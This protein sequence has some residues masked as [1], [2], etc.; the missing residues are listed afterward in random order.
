[1]HPSA[2]AAPSP[3]LSGI[4]RPAAHRRWGTCGG[5]ALAWPGRLKENGPMTSGELARRNIAELIDRLGPGLVLYVDEPLLLRAFDWPAATSI[6]AATF[7][8]GQFASSR[9]CSFRYDEGTTAGL[10]F[11]DNPKDEAG[12]G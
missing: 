11:R 2:V 1:V 6:E 8:A 9:G 7:Q 5:T 12:V 3:T 10:F 4:A